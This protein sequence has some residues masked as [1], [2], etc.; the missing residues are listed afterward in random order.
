MYSTRLTNLKFGPKARTLPDLYL[1]TLLLFFTYSSL[2]KSEDLHYAVFKAPAEDKQQ[3]QLTP[4]ITE[5]LFRG[6]EFRLIP[7][8][9]PHGS[10]AFAEA[11]SGRVDIILATSHKDISKTLSN[12]AFEI[13]PSPV[14]PTT[15]AFFALRS[16][17]LT[18]KSLDRSEDLRF[19]MI[20]LPSSMVKPL[21]GREPKY[22]T[23]FSTNTSLAKALVAN[24]IDIMAGIMLLSQRSFSRLNIQDQVVMLGKGPE[25]YAHFYIRASLSQTKKRAIYD[26]LDERIPAIQN[27]GTLSKLIKQ[28]K[29]IYETNLNPTSEHSNSE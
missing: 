26:I 4:N 20:R 16:S 1:L 13:H 23:T 27:N 8:V 9:V 7:V 6:S 21:L 19:G 22:L 5:A 3:Y 29:S 18:G 12:K 28:A 17:A 24:H 15:R 10:R 25:M 11:N 2:V 14:F